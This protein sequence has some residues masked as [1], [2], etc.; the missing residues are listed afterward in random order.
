MLILNEAQELIEFK[1]PKERQ[2]IAN[3]LKYISEEAR[4]SIVL[5]GMPWAEQLAD[6]PQWSSRLTR[7]RTLE[8]FSLTKARKYY[9]QYLKALN[10]QLPI[11]AKLK[12]YDPHT[13]IA[14]FSVCR[15][16][17]RALKGLIMEALKVCF[18]QEK[19]MLDKKCF[20]DAYTN[21]YGSI[22]TDNPFLQ[23]IHNIKISEV[24]R[25]SSYN[26]N[27]MSEYDMLSS[28]VFSEPTVFRQ[29]QFAEQ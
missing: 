2:N 20:A 8:Y 18:Y 26:P 4:V 9:L 6:E 12:L 7:R 19:S 23:D 17:N 24:V 25:D 1:T 5:V 22:N 3:T 13:S 29:L 21:I 16:E 10:C 15:G 28:R 14:L 11:D 27:A